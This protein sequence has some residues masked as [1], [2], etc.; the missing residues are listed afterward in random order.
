MFLLSSTDELLDSVSSDDDVR[1]PVT[2]NSGIRGIVWDLKLFSDPSSPPPLD[3]S[4][5]G[6]SIGHLHC[7]SSVAWWDCLVAARSLRV[8]FTL[9]PPPLLAGGSWCCGGRV[10]PM[11]PVGTGCCSSGFDLCL[12]LLL[13]KHARLTERWPDESSDFDGF[14]D[15]PPLRY[16]DD[17]LLSGDEDDDP[18]RD[19]CF[20]RFAAGFLAVDWRVACTLE[21]EDDDDDDGSAS[22]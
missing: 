8:E 19:D 16:L 21:D 20:H 14:N 11:S 7:G 13:I 22:E 5:S 18:V 12:D 2:M 17:W 6:Y 1:L 4:D 15:L 9:L 10:Y 3:P